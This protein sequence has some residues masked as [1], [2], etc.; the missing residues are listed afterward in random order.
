MDSAS[1]EPHPVR[2]FYEEPVARGVGDAQFSNVL[3]AQPRV[4]ALASPAIREPVHLSLARS[5]HSDADLSGAAC[6]P[7][8]RE[9]SVRN[10]GHR[11]VETDPI[12]QR[13]VHTRPITSHRPWITGARPGSVPR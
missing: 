7:M 8:A 11:H 5:L 9:V 6:V 1:G 4:P 2:G 12:P 10:G 3:R 13:T